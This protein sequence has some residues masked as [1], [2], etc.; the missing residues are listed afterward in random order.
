M[1]CLRSDIDEVESMWMEVV[2]FR[3]DL[4]KSWMNR[5]GFVKFDVDGIRLLAQYALEEGGESCNGPV[6]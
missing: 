2:M 6:T 5:H 1:M 3:I 4:M